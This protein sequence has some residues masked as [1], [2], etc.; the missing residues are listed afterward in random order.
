MFSLSKIKQRV[1]ASDE[2]VLVS[3]EDWEALINKIE[4]SDTFHAHERIERIELARTVKLSENPADDCLITYQ[5]FAPSATVNELER[6]ISE[7]EYSGDWKIEYH[8]FLH[9]WVANK[10]NSDPN[11]GLAWNEDENFWYHI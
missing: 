2:G 5:S 8:E 11:I 6:L 7:A 9:C 10:T 4:S 3:H 1:T